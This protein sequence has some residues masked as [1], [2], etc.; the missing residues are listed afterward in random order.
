MAAG[1]TNI[2]FVSAV[3]AVVA[4]VDA[5]TVRGAEPLYLPL[6][7]DGRLKY[8]DPLLYHVLLCGGERIGVPWCGSGSRLAGSADERLSKAALISAY[9]SVVAAKVWSSNAWLLVA[10][11]ARLSKW[12]SSCSRMSCAFPPWPWERW[13]RSGRMP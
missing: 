7:F 4:H 10:A 3:A 2:L 13:T 6:I 1:L 11:G 5:M 9:C 8:E 12:P